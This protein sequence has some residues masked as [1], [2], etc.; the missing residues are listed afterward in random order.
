M[1]RNNEELVLFGNE[2]IE[3]MP[4]SLGPF[5]ADEIKEVR[6]LFAAEPTWVLENGGTIER[7]LTAR[8]LSAVREAPDH[9]LVVD[10]RVQNL[11]R[12]AVPP[13]RGWHADN[14]PF[15]DRT[16]WPDPNAVDVTVKHCSITFSDDEFGVSNTEFLIEPIRIPLQLDRSIWPQIDDHVDLYPGHPR[17]QVPDGS[18]CVY[19][20]GSLHRASPARCDGWRLFFRMVNRRTS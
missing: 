12:G 5:S 6:V 10:T 14:V 15:S 8:A 1:I 4:T 19:D 9:Q 18:L 3:V 16:K 7:L 11:R 20:S 2:P 13:V 17:R